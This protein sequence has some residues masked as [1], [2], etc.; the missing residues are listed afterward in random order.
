[1]RSDH[2]T[3]H[4]VASHAVRLGRWQRARAG[5]RACVFWHSGVQSHPIE[6]PCWHAPPSG[7]SSASNERD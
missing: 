7:G 5:C 2:H 4:V 3:L 1:L 6:D